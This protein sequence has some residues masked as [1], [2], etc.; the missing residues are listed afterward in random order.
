MKLDAGTTKQFRAEAR[1]HRVAEELCEDMTQIEQDPAQ[2]E[3]AER[4]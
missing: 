4:R 2:P 3:V 1:M